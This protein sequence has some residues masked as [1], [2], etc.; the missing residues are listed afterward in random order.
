MANRDVITRTG[1]AAALT[2]AQHDQNLNSISGTVEEQTGATYTV[3]FTDQNK[4]IE[5]NNASMACTL[6]EIATIA[7]AI[8]T[9]GWKVTLKN[10]NAA[11]ATVSRSSTDTIDGDTSL[12]LQQYDCVTLS[13]NSAGSAWNKLPGFYSIFVGKTLTS[14]DDKIDN[15]PSGTRMLFQQTSRTS[16]WMKDTDAGL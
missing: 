8:D 2:A 7:A 15:F 3:V 1:A 5:L 4:V 11:A 9:D 6:D 16:G 13:I 14:T 12:T 10:T